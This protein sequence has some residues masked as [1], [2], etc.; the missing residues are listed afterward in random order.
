MYLLCYESAIIYTISR[1][2]WYILVHW[3]TWY[4]LSFFCRWYFIAYVREILWFFWGLYW[5]AL[6]HFNTDDI[7]VEMHQH[8]IWCYNI[9]VH[10]RNTVICWARSNWLRADGSEVNCRLLAVC[11][12][13]HLHICIWHDYKMLLH[14]F[15]QHIDE[16]ECY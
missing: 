2:H 8:S 7:H 11:G 13:D 14:Y 12:P 6:M 10:W 5:N 15:P 16:N 1:H 9:L 3:R 4:D